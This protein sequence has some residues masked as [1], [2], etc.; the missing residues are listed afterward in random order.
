MR[1][2]IASLDPEFLRARVAAFI[3]GKVNAQSERNTLS[4]SVGCVVA[5]P[6]TIAHGQEPELEPVDASLSSDDFVGRDASHVTVAN[7]PPGPSP[8]RVCVVDDKMP[9]ASPEVQVLQLKAL[10]RRIYELH[11]PPKLSELDGLY[12]KYLGDERTLYLKVCKKYAVD[13]HPAFG[14]GHCQLSKAQVAT[15]TVQAVMQRA[16][17]RLIPCSR[18]LRG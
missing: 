15:P 12:N 8:E 18:R 7:K 13:P 14:P 11:N 6:V 3:E 1:E 4:A 10:V 16:A 2:S 17:P 5:P 9:H